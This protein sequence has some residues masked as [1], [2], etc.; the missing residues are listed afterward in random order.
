MSRL[1]TWGT[2]GTQ[3]NKIKKSPTPTQPPR[4]KTRNKGKDRANHYAP[5]SSPS[6]LAPPATSQPH[7]LHSTR[8]QAANLHF[9][10]AKVL[11]FF[12]RPLLHFLRPLSSRSLLEKEGSPVA[13]SFAHTFFGALE[14][15]WMDQLSSVSP[16]L[17]MIVHLSGSS[18]ERYTTHDRIL[19]FAVSFAP[20]EEG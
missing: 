20:R 4:K 18:C 11:P 2:W 15:L 8:L 10:R 17:A 12:G 9:Q 16:F 3:I 7:S 6:P 13:V 1:L 14:R 19:F 5:G